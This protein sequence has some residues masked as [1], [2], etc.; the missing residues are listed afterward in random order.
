MYTGWLRRSSINSLSFSASPITFF[1]KVVSLNPACFRRP[2]RMLY[3]MLFSAALGM[4]CACGFWIVRRRTKISRTS[5]WTAEETLALLIRVYR[6]RNRKPPP[7]RTS[8][9]CESQLDRV[10]KLEAFDVWRGAEEFYRK[11]KEIEAGMASSL[12]STN[13][14]GLFPCTREPSAP[15]S[16]PPVVGTTSLSSRLVHAHKS[17]L[18]DIAT[19]SEFKWKPQTKPLS[20][21]E[22][23]RALQQPCEGYHDEIGLYYSVI[24]EAFKLGGGT[25]EEGIREAACRVATVGE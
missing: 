6:D 10:H 20:W 12:H 16:P 18:S 14:S 1:L 4:C 3:I 24:C 9:D 2:A 15:P 17:F 23:K 13:A 5:L 19:I 21:K 22:V 8:H 11:A 25:I 7:G